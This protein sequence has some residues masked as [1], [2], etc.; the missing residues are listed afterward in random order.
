MA[1]ISL[2]ACLAAACV[3]SALPSAAGAATRAEQQETLLIS[4]NLAGELPNG[5]SGNSVISGDKRYAR[6]IAFE[7]QA[8]DLVAG[9]VNGQQDVF[10]VLRGGPVGNE[11][12]PWIPD[13][14]VLVSRTTTGEPANG[15]S[16]APSVDGA[17]Q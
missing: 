10:A 11:G 8:S 2:R 17:F 1:P 4:H 15:P 3:L 16:F 9:D 14:T 5:P 6:V 13:K 7:S 12:A